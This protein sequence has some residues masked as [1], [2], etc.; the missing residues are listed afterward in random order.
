VEAALG[1]LATGGTFDV[2]QAGVGGGNWEMTLLH[3][4]MQGKAL[5]FK[6]SGVREDKRFADDQHSPAGMALPE[7]LRRI[8]ERGVS[9]AALQ[10]QPAP[11]ASRRGATAIRNPGIS[12]A[13]YPPI[14]QL[15][16]PDR[17]G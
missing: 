2:K 14:R 3:V 8:A 11:A 17:S 5:F 13:E 12:P 1:Q 4:N 16:W 9:A 15:R 7:A 10:R 6:T